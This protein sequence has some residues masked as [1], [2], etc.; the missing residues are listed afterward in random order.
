[1]ATLADLDG[2]I[3]VCE[4]YTRSDEPILDRIYY[5]T[6]QRTASHLR[7]WIGATVEPSHPGYCYRVT[8]YSDGKP[9]YYTPPLT[10]MLVN[11]GKTTPTK[12]ESEPVPP[13]R[14]RRGIE[15]RWYRGRWEKLLKRE[16]WVTA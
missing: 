11:G 1:M 13:P 10:V 5:S 14:V 8:K 6:G 12:G 4:E 9:Y 2:I 15:L 7:E 3:H 16:G